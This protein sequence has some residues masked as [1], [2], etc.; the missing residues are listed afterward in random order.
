MCRRETIT[1]DVLPVLSICTHRVVSGFLVQFAKC[2]LQSL[3]RVRY[4]N[5]GAHM[6]SNE[7]PQFLYYNHVSDCS[8]H[9]ANGTRNPKTTVLGK[10]VR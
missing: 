2:T 6:N 5:H 10:Y 3:T 9:C 8:V 7:A 4:W 1:I